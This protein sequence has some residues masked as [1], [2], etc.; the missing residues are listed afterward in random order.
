MN[1][2]NL[3]TSLIENVKADLR[4]LEQRGWDNQRIL[5]WIGDLR[6]CFDEIQTLLNKNTLSTYT[7]DYEISDA[8]DELAVFEARYA[9]EENDDR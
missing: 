2:S 5:T 8:I 7:I 6:V 3:T 1:I 9:V 4:S